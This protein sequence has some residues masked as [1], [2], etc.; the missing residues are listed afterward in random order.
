MRCPHPNLK[1]WPDVPNS[2]VRGV[3]PPN[4]K[5]SYCHTRLHLGFS[6]KLRIWQVPACKMEPRS[7]INSWKNHPPTDH[8]DFLV[9]SKFLQLE[10]E[11]IHHS[12]AHVF[13]YAKL[14]LSSTFSGCQEVNCSCSVLITLFL[15]SML[16]QIW[17]CPFICYIKKKSRPLLS[18][19]RG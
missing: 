8:M 6:A 5:T 16:P 11:Y 19:V 7:W 15:G 12:I 10:W 9:P 3:P 2:N 4:S 14:G 17:L 1:I 13:D 18:K